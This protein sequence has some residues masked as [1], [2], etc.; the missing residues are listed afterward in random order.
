MHQRAVLAAG[1]GT[2][3]DT[4]H[5]VFTFIHIPLVIVAIGFGAVSFGKRFRAYSIVTLV[6]L[7]VAGV[8]TGIDSPNI[9]TD[10]PTPWIG[11]WERVIIGVYMLWIV[12]LAVLLLRKHQQIQSLS[13]KSE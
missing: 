11:V 8:F 13:I 1:G 9:Q 4:M 7:I 10:M 2:W 5:I 12:V 3:T 6:I